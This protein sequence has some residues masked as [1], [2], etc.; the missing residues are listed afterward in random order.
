MLYGIDYN[1]YVCGGMGWKKLAVLSSLT[2]VFYTESQ[3]L[4]RLSELKEENAFGDF[5]LFTT[6]INRDEYTL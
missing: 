2:E 1:N 5:K 6:E 3:M 4:E